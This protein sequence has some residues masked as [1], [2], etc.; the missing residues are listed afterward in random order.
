LAGIRRRSASA[1]QSYT[2][3]DAGSIG[4][5]ARTTAKNARWSTP[6]FRSCHR[7]GPDAGLCVR[8]AAAPDRRAHEFGVR[9]Y[10]TC[11]TRPRS[12][13]PEPR[14]TE[15]EATRPTKPAPGGR[16]VARACRQHGIKSLRR[17]A[18]AGA[19]TWR[20]IT[21]QLAQAYLR[22]VNTDCSSGVHF[23]APSAC[24]IRGQSPMADAAR[25][26]S[27]IQLIYGRCSKQRYQD[28]ACGGQG[29]R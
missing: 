6:V 7:N 26:Q 17:R 2:V 23:F 10:G 19:E 1:W 29:L 9:S 28:P 8:N 5:M 11:Y 12:Y 24:G 14:G 20:Q 25:F 27:L 3:D 4:R 22:S 15:M 21:P 16:P 18:M 13:N